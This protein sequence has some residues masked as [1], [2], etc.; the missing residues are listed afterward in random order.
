MTRLAALV[1]LVGGVLGALIGFAVP[2]LGGSEYRS[3]TTI[4]F[5]AV[6]LEARPATASVARHITERMPSWAK[7][8]G[9]GVVAGEFA[10]RPG[11]SITAHQISGAQSLVVELNS[12][13]S[14]DLPARA[15]AAANAVITV[16][17]REETPPGAKVSR[18]AGVVTQPGG[19]PVNVAMSWA[20]WA[21]VLG[22]VLG[23]LIAWLGCAL[24]RPGPWVDQVGEGEPVEA[25]SVAFVSGVDRELT[26]LAAAV[27]T[28]R[29]RIVIGLFFF[30]IAGY[31][32]T[33][34]VAPPFI[35][36]LVAG[37][38]AFRDARWIAVAV[39]AL[40]VT[41]FPPKLELV[42]LGPV[43]PT[44]LEV[45]VVIGLVVVWRKR[46]ASPFAWQ[47][48]LLTAAVLVGAG[49]GFLGGGEFSEISDAIRA[50]VLVPLVFL[51]VYRAFAGK[52]TQLVAVVAVGAAVASAIELVAAV[53]N[54][55]RLLVDERSSVITGDDTAEVSRLSAPVLPL[56][57][58]L[59]I[60]LVSGAFP[61]KPRW[62]FILLA[63]PGLA[64][65]ALSFNRST[66]APLLLCVI[67]VAIARFGSRGLV[68]RLIVAA[69]I[70]A[71]G[72][73]LA[74]GGALG[75][76]GEALAARVT[77]LFSGEALTEDSL[78]DRDR[79]NIAAIN[80]LR[81]SPLTGTGV[82]VSYGG[83]IIGYDPLHDRTTVEVR[84]WIHN[85][86]L[87][88]WLW[89]GA[90][91]LL[92]AGLLMVRVAAVVAQ[93][94]A[95]GAPGTVPVVAAG[96]GL[97]CLAA[98]SVFQTT[99]IDRPTLVTVALVL[100]ILGLAASWLSQQ[101]EQGARTPVLAGRIMTR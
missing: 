26:A 33:G 17:T 69:A 20:I 83:E 4:V 101:D 27:R 47:L 25:S 71:L 73:G 67:V 41:V 8:A 63:L 19:E 57:A 22:G 79:E 68:K 29:G 10:L 28:R 56:W 77:S 82:G 100:A 13:T 36:L 99:L 85:Q 93:A 7:L 45:A 70:G 24:A 40:G 44:V 51:I 97:A 78:A 98:Q 35:A 58:P 43:T 1:V 72:L 86:Y 38:V 87:R 52:L 49:I 75:K 5:T 65:E 48:A 89:F 15:T 31:A 81:D 80:T 59:L 74:S 23:A 96:L 94:W 95:R 91:G 60:L 76:T 50:L 62:R 46:T 21:A 11:E 32:A 18:V 64:H 54:W 39:L 61:T 53:A 6:Q 2:T 3:S 12:P 84:P 42:K 30:A 14:A 34:S 92:A 55:E 16:V 90:F 37:Y 9:S 88:M 66:W